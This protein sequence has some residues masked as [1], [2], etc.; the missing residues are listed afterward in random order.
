VEYVNKGKVQKVVKPKKIGCGSIYKHTYNNDRGTQKAEN[1]PVSYIP[2]RFLE[3]NHIS[4]VFPPACHFSLWTY[5]FFIPINS[6]RKIPV[7]NFNKEKKYQERQAAGVV[8]I[9]TF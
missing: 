2:G 9:R 6:V 1:S 7:E 4:S 5:T 8:Q 3:S